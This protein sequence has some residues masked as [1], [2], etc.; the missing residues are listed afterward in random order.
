M[1][2]IPPLISRIE[3]DINKDDEEHIQLLVEHSVN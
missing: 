1:I 2:H 3:Q